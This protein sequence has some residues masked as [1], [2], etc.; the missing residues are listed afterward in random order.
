MIALLLSVLQ[1]LMLIFKDASSQVTTIV[2]SL[3]DTI[4]PQ[5][6]NEKGNA[7]AKNTIVTYGEKIFADYK[8]LAESEKATAFLP[9]YPL[10]TAYQ[11]FRADF[12]AVSRQAVF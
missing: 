1:F 10:F 11:T 12:L 9:S 6:W 8:L 4:T 7:K 3:A 2:D 5:A